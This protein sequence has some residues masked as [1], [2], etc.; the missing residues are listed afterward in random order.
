[1][2]R[3]RCTKKLL[4]RLRVVPEDAG[5]PSQGHLGDWTA[6]V[7]TLVRVPVVI[8]VNDRTLYPVLLPLKESRTLLERF[9]S[10]AL[11]EILKVGGDS[12]ALAR[13]AA[14]LRDIRFA[15]TASRSVLGSINE[16]VLEC[17]H[18]R[19]PRGATVADLEDLA[20]QLR[21]SI[22]GPLDYR[23]PREAA[24]ELLQGASRGGPG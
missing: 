21:N 3:L 17:Q 10:A 13:E 16:F 7:F 4:R 24:R 20:D 23:Q 8:C 12:G 1:M 18:W 2:I 14:A 11:A 15:R 6:H 19:H 5:A 22:W 9:R